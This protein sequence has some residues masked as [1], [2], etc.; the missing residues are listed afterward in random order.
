MGRQAILGETPFAVVDVETTGIG[1]GVLEGAR[2]ANRVNT[3]L[4]SSQ[5]P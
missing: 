2:G 5:L 1:S 3:R 4:S